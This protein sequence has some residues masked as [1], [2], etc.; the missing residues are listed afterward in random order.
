MQTT[1]NLDPT[2]LSIIINIL[3]QHLPK[4]TRVW[5]FGSRTTGKAKP[6]SDIDLAIDSGHP[7]TLEVLANLSTDFE[8]SDIPYKVDIVDWQTISEMFRD[9]IQHNKVRI[10]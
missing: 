5:I 2:N 1:I 9:K 6:Y 3:N 8:E 4:N 7:L 10:I